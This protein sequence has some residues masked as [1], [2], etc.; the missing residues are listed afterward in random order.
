MTYRLAPHVSR[1]TLHASR[2]TL[3]A[4][5]VS[6][7][8]CLLVAVNRIAYPYDIDFLENSMLMQSLRIA[9]GQPVYL[10]PNVEFVPHVYTP[11]YM[12][13]GGMLFRVTG[14]GYVPLRLM[15]FGA[16]LI[17]AFVIYRAARY[18]SGRGWLAIAC[19]G[20]YFGGYR[21]I[22]GWYELARVDSL[23]VMLALV[24][25][26]TG[27]Y[28]RGMRRLILSAL[29]MALV[30]YTK[31]TGV[32]FAVALFLYL[33]MAVG[34]RAWL[35]AA[36]YLGLTVPFVVVMNSTTGGWFDYYIF[37][38]AS[39][40]PIEFERVVTYVRFELLGLMISLSVMAMATALLG[41]RRS[42][43]AILLERPWLVGITVAIAVSG[44]GRASVGG[45]MNNLMPA[46]AFLCIAPALF[47]AEWK[48][49]LPAIEQRWKTS[50]PVHLSLLVFRL[51]SI[52]AACIAALILV[53]FILGAYNPFRFMPSAGMRGSGDR[54]IER[55]ASLDGEVFVM[56][57]PY[58]ALLAGKQPSAQ[59]A[60]VWHG[61]ER[62]ALP[63]P[64][65]LVSRIQARYYAA[66]LSDETLF[67]TDPPLLGLIEANYVRA[68]TLDASDAPPTTTGMFSQTRVVYVP[69][70]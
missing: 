10:P 12:W 48:A 9:H 27:V 28:A 14:P 44:L 60:I 29:A 6:T 16:T 59:I 19:A 21:I 33:L 20:L 17:S 70:K 5:F 57:H 2:L 66:I 55:I 30:F 7:A 62:G 68:E 45:A 13:L 50:E 23:F 51:A 1:F 46:Y 65:D 24:A 67:E 37:G 43:R 32:V 36:I 56:M 15:S 22:D 25:F 64:A 63:L 40:N 39:S 4:A 61:R 18:E 3:L 42:G 58:Y 31:Q 52:P 69:R 54:L 41:A 47:F 53:Q 38:I 11:L 34:R 26:G 35:F 49:W 8:T